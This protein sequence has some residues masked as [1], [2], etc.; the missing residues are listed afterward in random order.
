MN[1]QYIAALCS[2]ALLSAPAIMARAPQVADI[3]PYVSPNNA[4]ARPASFTYASDGNGYFLLSPDGKTIDRYD[5]RTGDRLE[6]VFDVTRTREFTVPSIQSFT[7]SPDG[8]KILVCT[9]REQIYRRSFK[10]KF[11]VYEI[12][13]RLLMPL[14]D[15]F[16]TQR[17]PVFS[18]DGRMVAFVAE[19]NNIYIRKLDYKSQVAVTTDGAVNSVINGVPDWVYEEEFTTDC[20]MTWSPDN[21][22]LCY[23]RY[24]ESRVPGYSL[25]LYQ[26]T[27][28]PMDRYAL[29]PGNYSYKYPVAGESNSTVSVHSYDV[30]T[31]KV[32]EIALP[33]SRIEYIPRIEYADTPERLIISTLNRDQNH[34]EIYSCNPKSTVVKSIYTEDSNA[35]IDPAAYEELRLLPQGMVVRSCRSGYSQLYLYSYSG[36][37]VRTLTK[38]DFDVTAFYGFDSK[39]NYYYQAAR[40]TPMDRSIY[41][42]DVK[43]VEKAISKEEGTTNAS[44]SSD[45]T[46]AMFDYSNVTTPNIFTINTSDG[47]QVRMAEDNAA[48]AAKFAS[49]P[50]KEFFTME[51]DGV[52]LNGYIIR[53]TDVSGKCPAVMYQYSGPGSQTVLNR[54][55]M[56]WEQAFAMKG[57]VVVCVDGRGTG[58][59]GRAF[60]DV[61]YRN[62]GYYETIDQLAAARYAASLPY[63]DPDRIGIFGWSY[64]GYETLMA[65]SQSN[66]PYA[67]AVAVAPV[68]DWRYYDTVYAE[69]YMLTPQQNEDGYRISAPINR[70]AFVKCPLMIMYGTA[71]DNV[72]P[73]NSLQYASTLQSEGTLFDMMVFTNKNHS[74]NGC[75][76]RA[77]VY[78]NMLRFFDLYLKGDR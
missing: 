10:G 27:C 65:I 28:G 22:T 15:S 8:G 6:T 78:G 54:W 34:F 19:D 45:M 68:T 32:K 52:K 31:R 77:V 29:Y 46:L 73:A 48:C 39:G 14:S 70:T 23:I 66:S 67:A 62:L 20:S 11:F 60:S 55:S 43:G 56:D 69:R 2:A 33:D 40:P 3:E 5:L 13:S 9:E 47:R 72:H 17:A 25:P 16:S 41:R 63:V 1:F 53:P 49:A 21:L 35:W 18:P 36:A 26:G 4:V 30:E 57:Y 38:G 42:V 59:R 37:L 64:G 51:S 58:G 24:D 44:F 12:R 7:F 71:D 76:A 75:G 61:V 74:I 50:R